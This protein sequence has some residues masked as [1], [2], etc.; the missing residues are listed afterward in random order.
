MSLATRKNRCGNMMFTVKSYQ[1]LN[2][3]QKINIE[4]VYRS[5][6]RKKKNFQEDHI[7]EMVLSKLVNVWCN[8]II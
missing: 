6:F 1:F 8:V 5:L 2:G 3:W 4:N 7:D